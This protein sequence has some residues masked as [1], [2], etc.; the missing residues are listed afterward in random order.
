[1]SLSCS[2]PHFPICKM[3]LVSLFSFHRLSVTLQAS[4]VELQ[5]IVIPILWRVWWPASKMAPWSP[6]QVLMPS[7]G[8]LS[9][10]PEDYVVWMIKYSRGDGTGH[11]WL[12]HLRDAQEFTAI[13]PCGFYFA[14]NL[15]DLS[16]WETPSTMSWG[17]SSSS[18]A[19][20]Q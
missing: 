20:W 6:L 19:S 15:S 13:I 12:R 14:L 8:M 18:V 5:D 11:L 9:Q 2:T 3:G 16:P 17:H 4:W 7:Y 10:S 1:M